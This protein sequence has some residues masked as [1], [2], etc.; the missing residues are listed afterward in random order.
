MRLAARA[1][2]GWPWRAMSASC[3]VVATTFSLGSALAW[4]SAI[5]LTRRRMSFHS[6]LTMHLASFS[7]GR[8]RRPGRLQGG[9]ELPIEL[10]EEIE[11]RPDSQVFAHGAWEDQG[12][13]ARLTRDLVDDR[14]VQVGLC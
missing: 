8:S 11:R 14:S 7:T 4:V 5:K 10:L 6:R 3:S 1:C 12:L 13:G 9:D 2:R